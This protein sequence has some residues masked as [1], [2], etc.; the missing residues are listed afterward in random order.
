MG[1]GPAGPGASRYIRQGTAQAAG[2]LTGVKATS[3]LLDDDSDLSDP[4]EAYDKHSSLALSKSS[5]VSPASFG[6]RPTVSAAST[7]SLPRISLSQNT[8]GKA[9]TT[10]G[11]STGGGSVMADE[12]SFLEWDDPMAPPSGLAQDFSLGTADMNRVGVMPLSATE[13]TRVVSVNLMGHSGG[14]T[15]HV[16]G[17][18]PEPSPQHQQQTTA[19][20]G[21]LFSKWFGGR[22][23]SPQNKLGSTALAGFGKKYQVDQSVNLMDMENATKSAKMPRQYSKRNLGGRKEKQKSLMNQ[24]FEAGFADIGLGGDS[25]RGGGSNS[26]EQHHKRR[27]S[28]VHKKYEPTFCERMQACVCG[29]GALV[30]VAI[31][32][33]GL[34]VLSLVYDGSLSNGGNGFRPPTPTVTMAP[35]ATPA[36]STS[37]KET[38]APTIAPTVAPVDSEVVASD[39]NATATDGESLFASSLSVVKSAFQGKDKTVAEDARDHLSLGARERW[40]DLVGFFAR[41]HLTLKEEFDDP[42]SAPFRAL[43][44]IV[45]YDS[46]MEYISSD[47]GSQIIQTYALMVFYFAT[48][49]NAQARDAKRVEPSPDSDVYDPNND[50]IHHSAT[51][52]CHWNG[53]HCGHLH[54]VI[55]LNLTQHELQGTLPGELKALEHLIRLDLSHNQIEGTLPAEYGVLEHLTLIDLSDNLLEGEYP[56]SWVAG[57][58]RLETLDLS[59]NPG[60][61]EPIPQL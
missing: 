2:S 15:Q 26:F 4:D 13:L 60:L 45:E 14:G 57:L 44:W 51:P 41:N 1:H 36:P 5:N 11:G 50:W 37:P 23:V 10:G 53:I 38:P 40:D 32:F 19:Q 49:P 46:N 18:D 30:V 29:L 12:S 8:G 27:R 21:G 52:V 58:D 3:N 31:V 16:R 6:G 34:L 54:N 35:F 33:G 7:S 55:S 22:S 43:D 39:G 56:S 42:S 17:R 9:T 61:V 20:P 25:N 48:H 28:F 59:E 24:M 47:T